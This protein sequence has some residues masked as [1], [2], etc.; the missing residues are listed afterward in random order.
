MKSQTELGWE[1]A[2]KLFQLLNNFILCNFYLQTF[3]RLS[4]L[5]EERSEAYANANARVSLESMP[6]N[7]VSSFLIR[8]VFMS[9]IC[10]NRTGK[11]V[12]I[13]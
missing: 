13:Y 4:S 2:S 5:F 6:A 10:G 11:G 12:G 1:S 7:V 3:M 8:V 9:R